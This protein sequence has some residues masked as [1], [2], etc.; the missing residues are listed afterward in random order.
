MWRV[1]VH[2]WMGQVELCTLFLTAGLAGPIQ[3]GG[4]KQQVG[5]TET[6][7][8]KALSRENKKT[9]TNNTNTHTNTH[10]QDQA[11]NQNV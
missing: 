2:C 4:S 10:A 3:G 1:G 7:E 11:R 5:D 8:R 9:E 6:P